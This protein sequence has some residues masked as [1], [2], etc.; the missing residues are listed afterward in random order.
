MDPTVAQNARLARQ[1]VLKDF[2]NELLDDLAVA[3]SK[4]HDDIQRMMRAK[5]KLNLII[6]NK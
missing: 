3:S 5:R 6:Q 2:G 1:V 4:T